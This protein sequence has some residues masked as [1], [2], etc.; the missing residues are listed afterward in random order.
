MITN[1]KK[2]IVLSLLLS[3]IIPCKADMTNAA[4]VSN[5]M[6]SE[7][8]NGYISFY[9]DAIQTK[10]R[11]YNGKLQYRRWNYSKQCWV[12]SYWRNL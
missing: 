5:E 12:D 11:V 7:I 1:M 2:F 8:S 10:Y 3:L 6:T 4:S 9:A